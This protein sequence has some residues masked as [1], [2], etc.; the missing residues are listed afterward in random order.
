MPAIYLIIRDSIFVESISRLLALKYLDFIVTAMLV[1]NTIRTAI[2]VSRKFL[3]NIESSNIILSS[4]LVHGNITGLYA[5]ANIL[6]VILT[7]SLISTPLLL[8]HGSN[9]YKSLLAI[10]V[11]SFLITPLVI[12]LDL[13][14]LKISTISNYFM[15]IYCIFSGGLLPIELLTMS[16]DQKVSGIAYNVLYYNPIRYFEQVIRTF[17]FG[18]ALQYSGTVP[19]G[20]AEHVSDIYCAKKNLMS[21]AII[22]AIILTILLNNHMIKKL[23]RTSN[24]F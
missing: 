5:I 1:S 9:I 24:F 6:D 13:N 3:M 11:L 18:N 22:L 7:S 23:Q 4:Y 2:M 21:S 15:Y 12:I 19:T 17:L 16:I 14:K 8:L 10:G 20:L